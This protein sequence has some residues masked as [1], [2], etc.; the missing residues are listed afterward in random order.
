MQKE[1]PE[2]P[3]QLWHSI[4]LKEKAVFYEH[5][6]NLLDGGVT[7][8]EALELCSRW[9]GVPM[10]GLVAP[11]WA[12]RGLSVLLT[13]FSRL[14]SEHRDEQPSGVISITDDDQVHGSARVAA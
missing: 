9:S 4:S 2:V 1:F 12:L 8:L 6:S 7:L 14:L 10:P 3:V 11:P 13:P 5:I